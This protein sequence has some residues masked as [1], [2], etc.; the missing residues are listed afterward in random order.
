MP[1]GVP[2]PKVLSVWL[3]QVPVPSA[4]VNESESMP[5]GVPGPKVLSVWLQQSAGSKRA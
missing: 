5:A 2:G 3:Q 4:L 1:A